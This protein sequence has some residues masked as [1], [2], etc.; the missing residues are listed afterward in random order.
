MNTNIEI[1]LLVMIMAIPISMVIIPLLAKWAPVLG[2]IDN[3]D[4]RKVHLSPIPRVGGPGIVLGA[5]VP[6]AIWLPLNDLTLA[7]LLG[8]IA[9]LIFGVWDDIK[10]LGHYTKFI[11]QFVAVILV[12]YYG[13]LYVSHI[14]FFGEISIQLGKV[15]TVIAM[16]GVIN[17]LNHSDG[18]D[19]L[20]GGEALLSLGAIV[21]LSFQANDLMLTTISLATIGGIFGFLRFN[22]HP[23]HVFMGDGGS[24][25]IGFTIAFVVVHLTQNS[26]T[27]LSPALPL[28]L[29]GLPIIDILAVLFQRVYAGMNW[30]RASKN[31]IHHRLLDLGF[32][33]YESVII[34]YS[35]QALLVIS[36]VFLQYEADT[37][38]ISIY[39][40]VSLMLFSWLILAKHLRWQAHRDRK[41]TML[42]RFITSFNSNSIL[43]QY[44]H[45]LI[46]ILLSIFIIYSAVNS[47]NIPKDL[48]I[49]AGIVFILLLARLIYSFKLWFLFLRLMMYVSVAFAA[50]LLDFSPATPHG[51]PLAVYIF[52]T[53][54]SIAVVI[55]LKYTTNEKFKVNPLDYLVLMIV[56]IL[57]LLS[58]QGYANFYTVSIT[59]QLIIL[60]YATEIIIK[61]MK[62]R[63]NGLTLSSLFAFGII[64]LKYF[65]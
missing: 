34:I 26:N 32:H 11:G 21:Y 5:L 45:T 59:I 65:L 41:L 12:V 43:M 9:L 53:V 44:N 29:I 14:P 50:Y 2:M 17:A 63:I 18:L 52:Y 37:L 38:L 15:F 40:L 25:F 28:L 49:A 20:A 10:Q 58:E 55:A 42:G 39:L 16:V 46:H 47:S 27:V 7:Y 4:P 1:G 13:D 19:G 54:I 6:V 60:F 51:Y 35:V 64:A 8:S 33:H 31:H 30:F 61:H 3:P 48:S 23:A 57:A 62:H 56:V 36:G 22:S 24:Q